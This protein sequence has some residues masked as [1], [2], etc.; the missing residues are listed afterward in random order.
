[1]GFEEREEMGF[2]FKRRK[3][4]IVCVLFPLDLNI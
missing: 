1:M 3:G 4:F 2:G